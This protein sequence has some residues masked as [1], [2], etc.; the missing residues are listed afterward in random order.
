LEDYLMVI[1]EDEFLPSD[2]YFSV[3]VYSSKDEVD[4]EKKSEALENMD[5]KTWVRPAQVED[6]GIF[7]RIFVG[8]YD[9]YK[10]AEEARQKML[11]KIIFPKDIH[12]VDRTYVYG[13]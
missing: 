10:K 11:K 5:Y 6:K 12:I 1:E 3:Q 13:E 8:Q 7:Y 4:A 9:S 2:N